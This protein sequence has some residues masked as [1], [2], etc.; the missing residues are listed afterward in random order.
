MAGRQGWQADL[1]GT[2]LVLRAGSA[3]AVLLAGL[4][5][6]S[7]DVVPDGPS[8]GSYAIL[9]LVPVLRGLAH[10]DFRRAE[11]VVP[12]WSDG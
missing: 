6:A 10:L 5:P 7:G 3:G 2:A 8:A 11:R 1:H 12:L 9:A 4:R